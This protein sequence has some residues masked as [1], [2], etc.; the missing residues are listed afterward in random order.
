MSAQGLNASKPTRHVI[1]YVPIPDL[2]NIAL[3]P[4][5]PDASSAAYCEGHACGQRFSVECASFAEMDRLA[6][7]ARDPM[8]VLPPW[9][10]GWMDAV[11][12]MLD[13]FNG[14]PVCR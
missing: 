5:P 3:P 8:T 10:R 13:E 11:A 12:E 9:A 4:G 2:H 1:A 14:S 6:E 7:A